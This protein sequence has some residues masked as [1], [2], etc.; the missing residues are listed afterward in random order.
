MNKR[1][2]SL[3][4]ALATA[5]IIVKCAKVVSTSVVDNLHGRSEQSASSSE[6]SIES[7]PVRESSQPETY[8][9]RFKL[10]GGTLVSGELTQETP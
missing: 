4:L 5:V 1:V 2:F 3:I 8:E 6:P 7:E 9:V 10:K